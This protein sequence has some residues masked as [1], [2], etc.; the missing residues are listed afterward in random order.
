MKI[1]VVFQPT[2]QLVTT[3]SGLGPKMISHGDSRVE[4]FAWLQVAFGLQTWLRSHNWCGGPGG[5]G[6]VDGLTL[7]TVDPLS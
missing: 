1:G 4:P 5:P 6:E 3:R 2:T 7:L